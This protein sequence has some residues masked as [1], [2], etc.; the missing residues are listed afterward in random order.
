MK[1]NT[2]KLNTFLILIALLLAYILPFKLFLISYA[3]LGP[4]H[5]ITEINWLHDKQY[6]IKLKNWVYICF[7]FCFLI[8]L[9]HWFYFLNLQNFSHKISSSI[10]F[11]QKK[12]NI[13]IFICFFLPIIFLYIKDKKKAF[14]TLVLLLVAAF[15]LVNTPS[16]NLWIGILIPT[17]IHVYFFTLLFMWYGSL[18]SNSKI[19]L[20]NVVLL[21]FI[22][23]LIALVPLPKLIYSAPLAYVIETYTISNFYLL[24]VEI[25][26][27]LNVSDGSSF[28]FSNTFTTKIQLFI[29]FAYTYHYLNW[30][31]KTTV[32]GWHTT[33]NKQKTII[34]LL[35]WLISVSLYLINYK[36]GLILLLFLS[37]LHVFLEF[38][39]NFI[40]IRGLVSFYLKK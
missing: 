29:S 34:F 33:I 10:A 7:I 16:F 3:V 9:P 12:S 39:I 8:A 24:N 32:I 21:A 1:F 28:D 35:L 6:F 20:F 22:P 25:S 18:K 5:Y 19:G 13:L 4:L 26:K 30:F 40:S 27:L 11:L 17:V 23:F 15:F 14:A 36:L 37:Y 38:P 2:D 31:S